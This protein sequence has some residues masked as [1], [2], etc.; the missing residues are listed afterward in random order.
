MPV[1]LP[2]PYDEGYDAF[3]MN[4]P[5]DKN[6]YGSRLFPISRSE[7]FRGWDAAKK[8]LPKE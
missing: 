5:R 4:I 8:G 7:W 6:P 3:G 1:N 2:R